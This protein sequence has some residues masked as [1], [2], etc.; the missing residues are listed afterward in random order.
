MALHASYV[1]QKKTRKIYIPA[2]RL[3]DYWWYTHY[4][5][6]TNKGS[7]KPQCAA[8]FDKIKGFPKPNL[9]Q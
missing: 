4:T 8:N 2:W 9:K 5:S 7:S 6:G 1:G 3:L